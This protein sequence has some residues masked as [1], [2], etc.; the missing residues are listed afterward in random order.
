MKKLLLAL[1]FVPLVSYS[2]S[3]SER[4]I[5]ENFDLSRIG[6]DIAVEFITCASYLTVKFQI[7]DSEPMSFTRLVGSDKYVSTVIS[8]LLHS[9]RG[10]IGWTRTK[11]SYDNLVSFMNKNVVANKL[12]YETLVETHAEKCDDLT[13][14]IY[15]SIDKEIKK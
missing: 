6:I 5:E 1:M 4:E 15:R 9:S 2:Q 12:T 8:T 3:Q 13:R 14:H 10:H 11:N 7:Q